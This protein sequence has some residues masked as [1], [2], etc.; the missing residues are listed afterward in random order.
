[1]WRLSSALVGLAALGLSGCSST[2]MQG[3]ADRNLPANTLHHIATYVAGPGPIAA[4]MQASV[5]EEA[6]KRGVLA[7]GG[8]IAG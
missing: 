2:T 3:Y 8:L 7:E 6:H 4:K 1:M 5:A